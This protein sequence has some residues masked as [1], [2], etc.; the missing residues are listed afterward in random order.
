ML[1]ARGGELPKPLA[2]EK[3]GL[4][5][6]T[7]LSARFRSCSDQANWPWSVDVLVYVRRWQRNAQGL[8]EIYP[9]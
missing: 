8:W 1:L 5:P 4:W 9:V 6:E 3:E 7:E 2:N